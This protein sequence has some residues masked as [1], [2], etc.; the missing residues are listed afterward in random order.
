MGI[1]SDNSERKG[2][3]PPITDAAE[4][5]VQ[6]RVSGGLVLLFEHEAIHEPLAWQS[7]D[8]H[9]PMQACLGIE[10]V[11]A[12]WA[13]GTGALLATRGSVLCSSS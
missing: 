7:I 4:D 9:Q 12:A 3:R 13:Q 10:V 11:P 5:W 1:G 2:S 6:I 8:G